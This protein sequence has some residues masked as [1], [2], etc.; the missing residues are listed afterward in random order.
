MNNDSL[1]YICIIWTLAGM[2]LD[3]LLTATSNLGPRKVEPMTIEKH[4][5]NAHRSDICKVRE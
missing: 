2:R 3:R 4:V 5:H 1:P